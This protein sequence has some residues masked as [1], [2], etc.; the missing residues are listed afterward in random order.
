MQ[1][2]DGWHEPK[3]T[4]DLLSE[5]VML[6]TYSQYT[7]QALH[8]SARIRMA[9]KLAKERIGEEKTP[10]KRRVS[11]ELQ[12][13]IARIG[14][15]TAENTR[16]KREND[17]LL[18]QFCRWAYNASNRGVSEDFLNQPLPIV[19]RGQT[20]SDPAPPLTYKRGKDKK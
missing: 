5:Q 20:P 9:Y 17:Q 13:A 1:I 19:F 14:T 11:K 3:L 6:H 8:K 16:L 15:L 2:L 18:E 7:R 12:M 4:W 10:P